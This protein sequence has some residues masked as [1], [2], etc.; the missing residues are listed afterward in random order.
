MTGL[1]LA[2]LAVVVAAFALGWWTA[3]ASAREM[4]LEDPLDGTLLAVDAALAMWRVERGR[5][6]P[7]AR[8]AMVAAAGRLHALPP[9]GGD[10]DAAVRA[11]SRALEAAALEGRAA[12]RPPPVI[13]A[14]REI[15][16]RRA[17][18]AP[19]PTG[20]LVRSV[21]FLNALA[22]DP[23][24]PRP[25]RW[26]LLFAVL[27]IPGPVDELA[28]ALALVLLRRLRPGVVARH[29]RESGGTRAGD[30]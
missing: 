4:P 6:S 28:G 30:R 24:I 5:L 9:L 18:P 3:T 21:R 11:L 23:D 14:A 20:A 22:A 26:L 29:W 13:S 27:P 15:L 16:G 25:V 10:D 12:S 17:R 1:Q 19:P 7:A 8:R 2:V